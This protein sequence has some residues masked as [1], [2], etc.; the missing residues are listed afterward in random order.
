MTGY[1]D[2]SHMVSQY[3][4]I[5]SQAL[6]ARIKE[7]FDPYRGSGG[8]GGGGGGGKFDLVSRLS[9]YG[10]LLPPNTFYG[11]KCNT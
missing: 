6:E 10:F 5:H 11:S 2:S 9:T 4:L 1:L 7:I 8:G 3:L